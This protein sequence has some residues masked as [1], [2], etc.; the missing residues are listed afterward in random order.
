MEVIIKGPTFNSPEDENVFFNCIYALPNF[1]E[2]IGSGHKL[3]IKF[4]QPACYEALDQLAVI[5][6][7]WDV[8]TAI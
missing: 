6:K 4:K 2:V 7:R 5:C 1:K 8:N 3:H